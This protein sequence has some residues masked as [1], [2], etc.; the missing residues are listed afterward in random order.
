MFPE[1][2]GWLRIEYTALPLEILRLAIGL[3]APTCVLSG[4]LFPLIG[5]AL[6]EGLP[7]PGWAAGL[8][9]LSNTA[10]ATLGALLG[11]F[12]LLPVLGIERS[13]FAVSLAYAVAAVGL[14][15]AA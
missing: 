10:G 11:G 6:R 4:C 14:A 9:T 15:A 1:L 3:M 7:T 5:R 13:I 8:L 2:R 12:V